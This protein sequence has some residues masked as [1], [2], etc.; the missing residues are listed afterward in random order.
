[1]PAGEAFSDRQHDEIVRAIEFA[2]EVAGL[3]VSVFVGTLEGEPRAYAERLHGALDGDSA[4]AVLVA[5]D[6]GARRLEIVSGRGVRQRVDDRTCG[7]AALT[8][9]SSFE[10]GDLAGGIAAGVRLLADH[11][12]TPETLHV[13]QS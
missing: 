7:L 11:A 9:T 10:G 13:R 12:R 4:Q 6:P 3:P 2:Q 8:M 5:V 1:M